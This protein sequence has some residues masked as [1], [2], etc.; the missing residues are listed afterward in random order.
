MIDEIIKLSG[1]NSPS[2]KASLIK[3]NSS[4]LKNNLDTLIDYSNEIGIAYEKGLS[5][6]SIAQ[7]SNLVKVISKLTKEVSQA[8]DT[9]N[10]Q[11]DRNHRAVD[12]LLSSA[13]IQVNAIT[14]VDKAVSSLEK[15]LHLTERLLFGV[16]VAL[17]IEVAYSLISKANLIP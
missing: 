13:G 10:D 6:C 15:R 5:E 1:D 11:V 9:L 17:I 8:N 2:F 14:N 12:S 16:S 4:A 3:S 7:N